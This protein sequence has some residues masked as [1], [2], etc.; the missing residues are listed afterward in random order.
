MRRGVYI[1]VI[2]IML[3]CGV[4]HAEPLKDGTIIL[5][6]GGPPIITRFIERRI[7][8]QPYGHIAIV[9]DNQ[10]YEAVV[11]RVRQISQISH[12]SEM[13]KMRDKAERRSRGRR[14]LRVEVWEPV[15]DYTPQEVDAMKRTAIANINRP[16]RGLTFFHNRPSRGIHCTSLVATILE[17]TGRYRFGLKQRMEPYDVFNI[18]RPQGYRLK[19]CEYSRIINRK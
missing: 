8:H 3:F 12:A 15:F 4:A 10:I 19:S 1:L 6:S 7:I 2:L 9:L 14:S 13:V 17:A 11:P 5:Y 18:I 16:Y